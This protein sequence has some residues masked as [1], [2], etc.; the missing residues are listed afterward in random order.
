MLKN[1]LLDKVG[2][3]SSSLC[4]LHCLMTAFLPSLAIILGLDI[5]LSSQTEWMFS[6]FAITMAVTAF[7]FGYRKHR[8]KFVAFLFFTGITGV[9]LSR[10]I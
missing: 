1:I 3:L 6:L 5:L 2:I 7:L 8:S 10:V 4:A 9:I